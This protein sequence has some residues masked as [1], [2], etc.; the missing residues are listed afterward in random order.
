MSRTAKYKLVYAIVVLLSLVI[1]V[2]L[3]IGLRHEMAWLVVVGLALLVPGRLAGHYLK[4]LFRARR[5]LARER[6]P[7]AIEA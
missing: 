5:M 7:E 2:W 3:V 1:A 4:D 6:Y